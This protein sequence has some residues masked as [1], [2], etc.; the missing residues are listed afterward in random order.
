MR[1]R[2]VEKALD[3]PDYIFE[4]KHDGFLAVTYLQNGE[5]KILSRNLNN[6]RFTSL[7]EALAKL[8]V[9]KQIGVPGNAHSLGYEHV[10]R[11]PCGDHC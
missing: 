5:C 4:L 1:L 9:Q 6:L 10:R 7:K 3:H 8:P 2:Q 11:L